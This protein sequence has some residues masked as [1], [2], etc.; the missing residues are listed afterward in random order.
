[1][2]DEIHLSSLEPHLAQHEIDLEDLRAQADAVAGQLAGPGSKRA[3]RV[4]KG[5]KTKARAAESAG[6]PKEPPSRDVLEAEHERLERSIATHERL[7]EMGRDERIGA[8]L[9]EVAA[10]RDLARAAAANPRAFAIERGIEVP[11][12]VVLDMEVDDY[13]TVLRISNLDPDMP[14]VLIWTPDGFQPPVETAQ[15][16]P[17]AAESAQHA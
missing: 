1:M 10:D 7:I 13:A 6:P 16:E 9:A 17:G 8:V 3:R 4:H 12:S 14:F 5:G 2:S 11:E 15:G